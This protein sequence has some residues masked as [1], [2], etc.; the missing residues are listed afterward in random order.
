LLEEKQKMIEE[1]EKVYE[2]LV[3]EKQKV[4]EEKQKVIEEK[5]NRIKD[6]DKLIA[7]VEQ[8]VLRAKGKLTSRGVLEFCLTRAGTSGRT[9]RYTSIAMELGNNKKP[10]ALLMKDTYAE[11]LKE[12]G[13]QDPSSSEVSSFYTSLYGKLSS[14]IHGYPWSGESLRILI[15]NL[16]AEEICVIRK[17]AEKAL[18]VDS[19]VVK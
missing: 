14:E 19:D 8:E 16:T 17:L 10:E 11:C 12:A 7:L 3:E 1:K 9:P 6:K 15:D 4:V 5:E 13:K 2:R 18:C